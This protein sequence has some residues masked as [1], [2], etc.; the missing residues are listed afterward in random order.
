LIIYAYY[1]W[2]IVLNVILDAL[3]DNMQDWKGILEKAGE[4]NTTKFITNDV[5]SG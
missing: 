4:V 5:T 1:S 2:E 3:F